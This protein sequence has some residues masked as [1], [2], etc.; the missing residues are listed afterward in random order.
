MASNK[1]DTGDLLD[2]ATVERAREI[3]EDT[4]TPSAVEYL[5]SQDVEGDLIEEVLAS[6]WP[7]AETGDAG[8][9]RHPEDREH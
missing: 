8:D 5:K 1:A 2:P 4:G 9:A 7:A 6:D 3:Q